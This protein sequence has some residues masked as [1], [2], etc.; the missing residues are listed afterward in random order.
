LFADDDYRHI[1]AALG[2]EQPDSDFRARIDTCY[3]LTVER[4]KREGQLRRGRTRSKVQAIRDA[5]GR[6]ADLHEGAYSADGDHAVGL[7]SDRLEDIRDDYNFD[8]VD[9][10]YATATRDAA[11]EV[12]DSLPRDQGGREPDEAL[13]EFIICLSQHYENKTGKPAGVSGGLPSGAGPE[14]YGGP[15]FRFIDACVSRL[16][17]EHHKGNEAMGRAIQRALSHRRRRL[18][19]TEPPSENQ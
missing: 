15:F 13:R 3:I 12:L 16:A 6:L 11:Q 9:P 4:I 2:L 8:P 1:E 18:G 7:I 14:E 5:A 17:P 19:W 10:F